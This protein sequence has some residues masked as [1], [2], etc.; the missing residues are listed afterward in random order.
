M[1]NS[2]L[3][4]LYRERVRRH[5]QK[6]ALKTSGEKTVEEQDNET[7][8]ITKHL[9]TKQKE[10]RDRVRNYRLR[11]KLSTPNESATVC[12]DIILMRELC[13]QFEVFILI[14]LRVFFIT[15]HEYSKMQILKSFSN[16]QIF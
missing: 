16:S 8:E 11:I 5:Q 4:A 12:E 15:K 13:S 3:Q 14:I 1:L 6:K 7:T 10:T 2:S 9:E